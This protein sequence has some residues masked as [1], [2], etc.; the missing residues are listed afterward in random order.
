MTLKGDALLREFLEGV[1]KPPRD[2][3]TRFLDY[4]ILVVAELCRRALGM[5]TREDTGGG[6]QLDSRE[7]GGTCSQSDEMPRQAKN[8]NLIAGGTAHVEQAQFE[9]GEDGVEAP[10]EQ[11]RV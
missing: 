5:P 2:R 9:N 10:R 1:E 3:N 6:S 11:E 4:D 8:G 7:V